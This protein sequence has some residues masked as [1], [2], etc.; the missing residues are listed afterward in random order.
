MPRS[1]IILVNHAKVGADAAADTIARAINAVGTVAGQFDA[2][3]KTTLPA[4]DAD[5]IVVLGGDGALLAQARRY[6]HLNLPILGVN[7]G[8]LG[9]LAEFD[10]QS[11]C[12]QAPTLFDDQTP[13][14]TARRIMLHAAAATTPNAA[15]SFTGVAMNDCVLTAGP[16]YRMIQLELSIDGQPGPTLRGD[17]VIIST[18]VGS[19]AYN[20]SAGGPIVSP[21]L[22]TFTITPI[23]VH[24]LAFRPI[25][26]P[27]ACEIELLLSG[28]NEQN[29]AL[30]LDGQIHT[31]IAPGSTVRLTRSTHTVTL[32][33]N[34]DTTF[35]ATL[36]RKLHWAAP[37]GHNSNAAASPN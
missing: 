8:N 19:T 35:W 11:F 24:S 4:A 22:E 14:L 6:A 31:P 1:A 18:P 28:S 34:P 27:S 10:V 26:L 12:D 29:A 33:R 9:F 30:V 15:P 20:V 5:M 23:A 32:V 13:L 2:N 3:D 37:P 25:V 17:G 7:V 16:S 21:D 36:I